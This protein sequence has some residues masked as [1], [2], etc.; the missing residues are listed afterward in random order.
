MVLYY[1]ICWKPGFPG[2]R[3]SGLLHIKLLC[4]GFISMGVLSQQTN[5]SSWGWIT[6]SSAGI[7]LTGDFTAIRGC[8]LLSRPWFEDIE[9]LWL[10]WP[11]R[12]SKNML[13]RRKDNQTHNQP[14]FSTGYEKWGHIHT[15]SQEQVPY[16]PQQCYVCCGW[17]VMVA[18]LPVR[19][20]VPAVTALSAG[21]S[22]PELRLVPTH[23]G[24]FLT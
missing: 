7:W 24:D 6:C 22:L 14:S 10:P 18:H 11:S 8:L 20:S 1:T 2:I 5:E 19:I 12:L 9:C 13:L 3:L 16:S 15:G 21:G 23:T 17:E 4:D